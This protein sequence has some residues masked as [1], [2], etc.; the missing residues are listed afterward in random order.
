MDDRIVNTKKPAPIASLAPQ[1]LSSE[2]AESVGILRNIPIFSDIGD[3]ELITIA[4]VRRLALEETDLWK[5][6]QGF[7]K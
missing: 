3:K 1:A 6:Y 4:R 7:F 2:L 5:V